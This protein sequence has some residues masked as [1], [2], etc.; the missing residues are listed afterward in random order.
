[1][2]EVR[3]DLG[4]V[5]WGSVSQR[6]GHGN[7]LRIRWSIT[8]HENKGGDEDNKVAPS[9]SHRN[10]P[11][12]FWGRL[13][14]RQKNDELGDEAGIRLQDSE[15]AFLSSSSVDFLFGRCKV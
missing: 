15:N 13:L 11:F 2:I 14:E 12:T 5:G 6:I 1:M 10:S 3:H 9:C 8:A 4:G 7:A